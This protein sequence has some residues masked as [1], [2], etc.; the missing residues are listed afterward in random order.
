[1]SAAQG[2]NRSIALLANPRS[3][4]GDAPDVE[5]GLRSLGAEVHGF[6]IGEHEAA[7]EAGADRI[8]VAGGDGSIGCAA[9]AASRAG[10]PLAV[11]AAGTANDFA[12]A[13][14][15]PDD[16]EQACELAVAGQRTRALDL[17]WMDER[18]FVNAAS[19]GLAPEAAR[20][21]KGWKDRLG[22]LAYVLGALRAGLAA[23]PVECEVRCDS[24]ELYSGRAWQVTVACSG[25]FGAGSSV[26]ADPA[27]ARLDVVVIEARSRVALVRHAR[28]LRAGG[29]EQQRGVRSAR[30]RDADVEVAAGTPF[31]VDGEVVEAGSSRFKL[32]PRAF[33]LVVG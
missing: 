17:A 2:G 20:E 19:A 29:V 27:D 33:D 25:A 22:P 8:V 13:L 15:L 6:E 16:L 26:D 21:A 1:M 10:V 32:E 28:G 24:A 7:A 30:G 3:G 31:N 14:E 23:S 5:A 12:R 4:G 9:S 11:V 18:P